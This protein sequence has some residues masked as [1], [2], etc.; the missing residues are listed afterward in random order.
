[1]TTPLDTELIPEII[2]LL[3]ELGKTV[4]LVSPPATVDISTQ[5]VGASTT[6]TTKITPPEPI[7][8]RMVGGDTYRYGDAQCYMKPDVSVAPTTRSKVIIDGESWS[9]IEAGKVYTGDEIGL[10]KLVLRNG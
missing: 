4:Q 2:A 6:E 10:Y 8:H 3:N 1:M 5:T 7:D 9:V